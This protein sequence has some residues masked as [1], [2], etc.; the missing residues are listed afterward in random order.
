M[1]D[2]SDV[3]S[4]IPIASK[5]GNSLLINREEDWGNLVEPYDESSNCVCFLK[6]TL[7]IYK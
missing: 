1:Y 4:P 7:V 6:L 5:I 3:G 2:N